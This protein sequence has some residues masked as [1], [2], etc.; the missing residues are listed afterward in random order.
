MPLS[1]DEQRT[2]EQIEN[3]LAREAPALATTF[4][5]TRLPSSSGPRFPLSAVHTVVL[6]VLLVVLLVAHPLALL[7]GPAGVGILTA[8]LI[9]PW[10]VSAARPRTGLPAH[11]FRGRRAGAWLSGSSG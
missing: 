6:V 5:A 10:L 9:V 1:P 8:A 11:R 3:E 2:L 4:A 7:L